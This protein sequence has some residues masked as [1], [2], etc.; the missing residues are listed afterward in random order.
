MH[1]RPNITCTH[2][3]FDAIARR[4]RRNRIARR[5]AG[6]GQVK[7]GKGQHHGAKK[8]RSPELFTGMFVVNIHA[9]EQSELTAAG[10]LKEVLGFRF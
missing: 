7:D 8:D 9:A 5:L 3:D 6:M 1:H 4:A 2:I 10:K